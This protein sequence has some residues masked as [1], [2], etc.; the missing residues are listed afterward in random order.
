M[1]KWA[2]VLN[3]AFSKE[4]VQMHKK[5][6]KKTSPSLAVK[7]MKIKTTLRFHLN[8]VRMAI[9]KNTNNNKFWQECGGK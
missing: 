3:R 9:I 8:P 4:E 1:K 5:Q 6:M 2:N 7:E